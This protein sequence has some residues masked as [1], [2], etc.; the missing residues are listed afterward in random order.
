[1]FLDRLSELARQDRARRFHSIAHWL[2]P[3]RMY[4]AFR[5]LRK[6]ASAGLDEVTYEEYE[7]HAQENIQQLWQRTKDGTYQALPLRRVYIPKDDG[8]RRPLSIPALE[9]KILQAATVRLL[10]AIYEEDFLPC[11]YGSRPGRSQHQ[12][13]DELNRVLHCESVK[14]LLELD[15]TA[16]FDSIGRQHLRE[17]IERRISDGSILKLIGKWINVGAIEAGRLLEAKEG[18]G[19]GQVISPLLANIYLHYV[20][21][22]WF[23]DEVKPRL[24]GRAFLVRYVDDAVICFQKAE[25]AHRVRE[26]IEKRFRRYGLTLHPEKTRLIEFGYD[27]YI[28]A[29]RTGSRPNTFDFLGFTHLY[30]RSRSG[31]YRPGVRTAKKRLKKAYKSVSEWCKTH[32]HL[33]VEEQQAALNRKLRGHYEYYGRSSNFRQLWKFYQ[34]VT[35]AWGI[36]L[37]RR[38]RRITLS[39]EQYESLRQRHPL[40][41]PRIT[42]RWADRRSPA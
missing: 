7:K 35:R 13:L 1:M 38:S 5:G 19:Q 12:G 29:A 33:P 18:V 39:W 20:L 24:K 40:L 34:L 23:E 8:K 10:N 3:E 42:H 27:T 37:R 4:E 41:R 30:E 6:D 25:D 2:T 16:Y 26:V 15:I 32:R 21:D 14:H 31:K 22:R 36:W 9:D 11:S 17:L 28:K